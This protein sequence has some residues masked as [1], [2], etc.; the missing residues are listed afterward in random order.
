[1]SEVIAPI[2]GIL[3][4]PVILFMIFVAP[5]WIIL[6]YRHRARATQGLGTADQ[7]K[8]QQLQKLAEKMEERVI[9]LESILDNEDP[10]WRDKL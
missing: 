1:M 3:I 8:M 9:A 7:N 2:L 6:H 4:T 5:I 10:N